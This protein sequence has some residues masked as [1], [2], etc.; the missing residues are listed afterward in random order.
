M[1]PDV[2]D[3]IERLALN[4]LVPYSYSGRGMY[5]RNCVGVNVESVGDILAGVYAVGYDCG[6]DDDGPDFAWFLERTCWD[7]MGLGWVYYWPDAEWPEG[8]EDE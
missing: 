5:G 8:R 2:D 3:F 7:Q 4:D 6:Q 1:K